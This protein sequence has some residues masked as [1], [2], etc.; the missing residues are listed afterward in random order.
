M[1]AVSTSFC[2]VGANEVIGVVGSDVSAI[3]VVGSTVISVESAVGCSVNASMDTVG[4]T[5]W[6]VVGF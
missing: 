3:I 1:A 4:A 5:V 6:I 2:P